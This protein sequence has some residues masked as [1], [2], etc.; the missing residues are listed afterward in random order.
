HR[1]ADRVLDRRHQAF[2]RLLPAADVHQHDIRPHPFQAVQK[3]PGI[4]QVLMLHNNSEWQ[5]REAGL[6]LLPEIAILDRQSDRQRV[7][8]TSSGSTLTYRLQPVPVPGLGPELALGPVPSAAASIPGSPAAVTAPAPW[9]RSGRSA[10]AAAPV[11][12]ASAFPRESTP[13]PT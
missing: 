7:H 4:P 5:I 9:V 12:S 11:P 2:Q 8:R 3:S 10:S 6:R 13:R 1:I